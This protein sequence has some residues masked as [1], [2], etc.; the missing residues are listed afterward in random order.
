MKLER[1]HLR[2][3]LSSSECFRTKNLS[4]WEEHARFASMCGFWRQRIAIYR[5]RLPAV[6]FA[7]ISTKDYTSFRWDCQRCENDK[8]TFQ[9]WCVISSKKVPA[10][11][12]SK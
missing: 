8:P 3:S 6:S 1:Y 7:A 10:A 12:K 4:G 5:R 9:C 2:S 11:L